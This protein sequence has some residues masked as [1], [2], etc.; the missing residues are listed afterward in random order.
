MFKELGEMQK[1]NENNSVRASL[2]SIPGAS[3]PHPQGPSQKAATF[4]IY[5]SEQESEP[6][7]QLQQTICDKI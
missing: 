2:D 3:Q 5:F 4:P 7:F 6:I 1:E